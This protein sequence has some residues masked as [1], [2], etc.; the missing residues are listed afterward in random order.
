MIVT[1]SDHN[2]VAFESNKFYID[3]I[4]G[5]FHIVERDTGIYVY[6]DDRVQITPSATN[7]FSIKEHQTTRQQKGEQ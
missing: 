1:K 6:A 5:K 3:S 2:D 7:A 4:H